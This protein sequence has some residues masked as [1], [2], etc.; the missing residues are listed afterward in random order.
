[1]VVKHSGAL[2]QRP[3]HVSAGRIRQHPV[4]PRWRAGCAVGCEARW[5]CP[6]AAL[7]AAQRGRWAS[8][9]APLVSS[10]KHGVVQK[11]TGLDRRPGSLLG[12]WL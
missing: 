3:Q 5:G 2:L 10:P 4:M 7:L 8:Q 6:H 9:N 1:V 11:D 12:S